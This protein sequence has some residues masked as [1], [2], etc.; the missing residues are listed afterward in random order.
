MAA[1]P[2]LG[3]DRV[4]DGEEGEESARDQASVGLTRLADEEYEELAGLTAA[5]RER[6]GFP[7]IVCVR[8]SG[9]TERVLSEGRQRL[10]NAPA[11]EHAAALIEIAKVANHRF[12]D[13][14]ADANPIATA[15]TRA[16]GG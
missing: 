12:A 1:Y 13:L 3:A 16:F 9:S 5:Y 8:D 4:A 11:Q 7:L 15:R 10:A 2:D 14:V 6:F